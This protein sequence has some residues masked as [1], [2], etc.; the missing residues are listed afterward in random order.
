[1]DIL[2]YIFIILLI[3]ACIG[4]ITPVGI[5]LQREYFAFRETKRYYAEKGIE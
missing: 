5:D 4:A 3:L 2:F 1:M